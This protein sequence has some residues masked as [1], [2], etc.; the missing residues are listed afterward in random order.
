MK[1]E[2]EPWHRL[3]NA[4]VLQA[5]SDYLTDEPQ[6]LKSLTIEEA[7][8]AHRQRLL[9]I[10]NFINSQWFAMLTDI[11]PEWLLAHLRK[12]R[13]EKNKYG[14]ARRITKLFSSE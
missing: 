14:I 1:Q 7:I 6:Y 10:E 3:A 5:C 13:K 2:R 11:D 12:L 9:D 8:E 4:I